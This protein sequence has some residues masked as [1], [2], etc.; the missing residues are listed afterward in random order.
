MVPGADS[1]ITQTTSDNWTRRSYELAGI[2]YGVD[3][4]RFTLHSGRHS[5]ASW[6]VQGGVTLHVTSELLGNSV[7]VCRKHYA[8]LIPDTKREAV[9]R[10]E[11]SL[12]G[13]T[14]GHTPLPTPSET[15]I[16]RP[17]QD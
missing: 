3:Q 10:M 13:H 17:R 4:G 5:F 11:E 2:P 14:R 1:P 6:L 7:E 9:K 16:Q 15:P 8:H 12:M